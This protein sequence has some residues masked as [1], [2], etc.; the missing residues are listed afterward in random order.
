MSFQYHR[1]CANSLTDEQVAEKEAHFLAHQ[2]PKP[3]SLV[4]AAATATVSVYWHVVSKDSTV[5]GGNVP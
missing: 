5:S 3:A 4:Q 2:V 1:G